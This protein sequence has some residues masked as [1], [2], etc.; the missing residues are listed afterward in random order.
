MAREDRLIRNRR[1]V[2]E[3]LA[4]D[5]ERL[6]EIE[7]ELK[8]LGVPFPY[9]NEGD[10]EIL[11]AHGVGQGSGGLAG[12]TDSLMDQIAAGQEREDRRD[13]PLAASVRSDDS[14]FSQ[15][16][17]PSLNE[18]VRQEI[19]T[20]L[21][22]PEE[23]LELARIKLGVSEE[24]VVSALFERLTERV[25]LGEIVKGLLSRKASLSRR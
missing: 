8:G 16:Q 2:V 20:I 9:D 7:A 15:E 12:A 4:K 24:E 3:S 10:E 11:K 18:M 13:E 1:R 23:L 6:K 25:D 21:Q 17:M 5:L 22:N 19:I 14:D